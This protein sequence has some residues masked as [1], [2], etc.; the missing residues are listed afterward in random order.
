M[1]GF[2]RDGHK[3]YDSYL[4]IANYVYKYIYIYTVASK[5][6]QVDVLPSI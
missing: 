3:Y 1:A 4:C 6:M 5:N 2:R